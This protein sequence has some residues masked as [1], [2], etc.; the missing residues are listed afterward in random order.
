MIIGS[1]NKNAQDDN[2]LCRLAQQGDSAAAEI[3]V[4][5]YERL[6]KKCA[7]P[8]FLMGADA[9]DLLQEGMLGLVLAALDY[10]AANG[11]PFSAYARL[12]ITHRIY[13]AVRAAAAH[14]HDPLNQSVSF[15][16]PLLEELPQPHLQTAG[17]V[18]D[19]ESLVIG[20]EE[21]EEM[22]RRLYALLSKFEAKV[23]SLYLN[24]YSYAEMAEIL[25]KPIKSVDNALQRIKRKTAAIGETRPAKS[26]R[27]NSKGSL[28]NGVKER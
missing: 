20:N 5:R 24:G 21:R 13:S 11:T 25:H 23:L 4:K 6:V 7:R 2:L 19:P 22:I 12:C 10:D 27:I 17:A 3:L 9:E 1:E 15:D 16:R 26:V 18:G 8:C 28:R 14:K